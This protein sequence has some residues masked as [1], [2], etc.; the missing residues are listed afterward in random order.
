MI[1][2]NGTVVVLADKGFSSVSD[3]DRSVYQSITMYDLMTQAYTRQ[4]KDCFIV[5]SPPH[6][7][8]LLDEEHL[9]GVSDNRNHFVIWS[10]TTGQMT[11]RIKDNFRSMDRRRT[12]AGARDGVFGSVSLL[13]VHDTTTTVQ[14]HRGNTAKM[15]PWDRRTETSAARHRRHMQEEE[16]ERQHMK[17]LHREKS[18]AIEQ[19]LISD[20]MSTIVASYYGHHLCV[21]DVPSLQHIQT[22]ENP[23]SRS[24]SVTRRTLGVAMTEEAKQIVIAKTTNELRVWRPGSGEVPRKICGYV[25]LDLKAG[26]RINLLKNGDMAVVFAGDIS[27]WDLVKGCVISV[28]TP[29]VSISCLT[30]A[31]EGTRILFGLYDK[32]EVVTLSLIANGRDKFVAAWRRR[33]I[34]FV[35]E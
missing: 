23:S 20:D 9:M 18:N 31:M 8:V 27:V 7:Y 15:T 12:N 25:G 29:D 14:R 16:V 21:F 30:V 2:R 19:F 28:F 6:E 10:L 22:L 33:N 11:N 32:S 35:D 4:L 3:E 13:A 34:R 24:G 26:T 17:D 1:T 5:P